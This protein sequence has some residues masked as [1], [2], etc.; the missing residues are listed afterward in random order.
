[1]GGLMDYKARFYS[2]YINRFLQPDT[3]IPDPSNP[4]AW[5][6]YFYALGVKW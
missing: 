4:Q 2:S 6:R 1:M 3:I 5:N